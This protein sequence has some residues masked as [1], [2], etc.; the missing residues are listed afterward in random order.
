[1]AAGFK[2]A[3]KIDRK[4]IFNGHLIAL[5]VDNRHFPGGIH[6]HSVPA[7]LENQHPT[8]STDRGSILGMIG[9]IKR[10]WQPLTY[11]PPTEG[12]GDEEEETPP[13]PPTPPTPR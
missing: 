13:T 6:I 5:C 1:M 10:V 4:L 7:R 11:L 9:Q 3:K 8:I 12:C 2:K